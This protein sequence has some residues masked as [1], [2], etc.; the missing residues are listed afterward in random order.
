MKKHILSFV[1]L[2]WAASATAATVVFP[3]S[4]ASVAGP[5]DTVGPFG[6][7]GGISFN[8][9]MAASQFAGVPV[10][11]QIT[12][13]GIRVGATFATAPNPALSGTYVIKLSTSLVPLGSLS[14]NFANNTGPN[15][16]T[17]FNG[18][19]TI[20]QNAVAGGAGPNPFYVINFTTPY[21]Y[22]GGDLL[23]TLSNTNLTG[24]SID[25]DAIAVGALADS[26]VAGISAH[27]S[28]VPVFQF[29]YSPAIPGTPAP[30]SITLTILGLAFVGLFALA[31]KHSARA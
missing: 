4:Y 22:T 1:F 3:N 24:G 21:T 25:I 8:Y 9:L 27:F 28:N 30:S 2:A 18:T 11:S 6:V 5:T 7:G 26:A 31:R 10:G 15:V 20:P 19:L 16:T 29:T 23:L 17:V 14:N 12:A 13:I